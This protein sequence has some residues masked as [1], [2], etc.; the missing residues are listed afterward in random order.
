MSSR[1]SSFGRRAADYDRVRPD[2]DPKAIE[3]VVSRLGLGRDSDVLDL[4]A[5]TG[6]LTRPLTALVGRVVAV[7]PDPGMLAVLRQVTDCYKALEGRAEAIP[8]PDGSV[9]AVFVGEAFHWF[10]TRE[11]VAEIARV[12][13][14]HGGLALV[15]KDWWETDPPIPDEAKA[16]AR[17]VYRRPDL[18]PHAGENDAWRDAFVGSA[19]EE[20]REE[21]VEA[22][23]LTLDGER[24]VTLMLST[25]GFGSL[26]PDQFDRVEAKLRALVVGDYRLP[27]ATEIHWTR[28]AK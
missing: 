3:L 22:E 13:R 21:R 25:S 1:A 9:D 5:G 12:L 28:L 18:E 26:P 8:L 20:L 4:A 27:I 24:L 15:W 11:A 7:E 16:V 6:K 2:Y 10:A 17:R 23:P 14:P 19:F